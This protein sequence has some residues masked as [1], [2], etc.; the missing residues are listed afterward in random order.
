MRRV[1]SLSLVFGLILY[2]MAGAAVA[3]T[4]NG[5][6]NSTAGS[7]SAERAISLAAR[8][9]PAGWYA[10]ASAGDVM[11][12]KSTYFYPKLLSGL[13]FNSLKGN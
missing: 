5:T 1:L 13:V 11:P 8:A 3:Q 4:S 7:T 9:H 2:F 12:Q 10:V 6:S